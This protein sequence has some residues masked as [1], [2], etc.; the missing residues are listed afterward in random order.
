ML[1]SPSDFSQ[2][3]P[4]EKS[5]ILSTIHSKYYSNRNKVSLDVHRNIIKTV[6]NTETVR[7]GLNGKLY[8]CVTCKRAL[9]TS[10]M[11]TQAV[12]NSLQLCPIPPELSD[13]NDLEERMIAQR[14]PFMKLVALPKGRQ[15]AIHGPCVNVPS[16]LKS[17]CTLLPRLPRQALIIPLKFKR[18]LRYR[19][20]YMFKHAR[21]HKIMTALKWLKKHNPLYKDVTVSTTW[22][23]D[24]L[25]DDSELF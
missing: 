24:C 17:I 11:P 8:I 5:E 21:P 20:Y 7:P 13:L 2:C 9:K 3:T 6:F 16:R 18:R 12:A 22:Q 10:K 19:S 4:P 25:K 14:T 1:L 15:Q 23:E